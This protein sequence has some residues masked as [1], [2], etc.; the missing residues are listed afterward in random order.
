MMREQFG[1][2]SLSAWYESCSVHRLAPLCRNPKLQYPGVE[3][4]FE[5]GT[6]CAIVQSELRVSVDNDHA[7]AALSGVGWGSAR[8]CLGDSQIALELDVR[9][10]AIARGHWRSRR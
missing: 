1:S 5:G 2:R 9:K 3:A 7:T 6:L 8:G 4:G 10:T